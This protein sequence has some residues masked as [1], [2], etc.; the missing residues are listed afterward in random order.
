MNLGISV[1]GLCRW[2]GIL[3]SVD[4][5]LWRF[6]LL[7]LIKSHV[8]PLKARS[9]LS[10]WENRSESFLLAWRKEAN[11]YIV[12]S[13][14]GHIGSKSWEWSWSIGSKKVKTSVPHSQGNEFCQQLVG[15]EEDAKPQIR[16]CSW[17]LD[18]SLWEL[19]RVPDLYLDC[20]PNEIMR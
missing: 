10:Q 4:L 2:N 5:K 16:I 19:N 15:L 12:I 6:I 11:S 7:G 13:L 20:W 3:K 9:F 17:Q 18:F 1:K 8:N 14:W